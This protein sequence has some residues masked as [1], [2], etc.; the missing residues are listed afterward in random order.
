MGIIH[1]DLDH[2]KEINDS[3][4]HSAGDT[5]LKLVADVLESVLQEKGLVARNGGD[6]FLAVIPAPVG[7]EQME[8][9]A[10][11][12]FDRLD[13]PV[14]VER[15]RLKIAGVSVSFLAI[16]RK[17][18]RRNWSIVPISRFMRPREQA[19]GGFRGT[20]MLSVRRIGT[21]A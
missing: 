6:E 8:G 19:A 12:I 7:R 2:F 20:P 1:F 16:R 3:L 18:A 15:Q 10:H 14:M 5:V 11:Q 21:G 17:R 4:G 13:Q 9:F